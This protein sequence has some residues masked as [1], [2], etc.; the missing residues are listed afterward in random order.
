M[1]LSAFFLLSTQHCFMDILRNS[2]TNSERE[3]KTKNGGSQELVLSQGHPLREGWTWVP[4][5]DVSAST[6]SRLSF[7]SCSPCTITW[8]TV[9]WEERDKL[10][11]R[12]RWNFTVAGRRKRWG[13][14][15]VFVMSW[16]VFW[17]LLESH[18]DSEKGNKK[19]QG[20]GLWEAA[21]WL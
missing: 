6:A 14:R 4:S 15:K 2:E 20:T 19:F 16:L 12:P 7:S 17:I 3:D 5:S 8:A 11:E 13:D 1:I 21:Q 10:P 9:A 18:W